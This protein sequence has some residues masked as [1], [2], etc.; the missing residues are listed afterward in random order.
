MNVNGTTWMSDDALVSG[1]E[2]WCPGYNATVGEVAIY[3]VA[4]N[5]WKST[6]TSGQYNAV[7]M[8]M[9]PTCKDFPVQ[10]Y[11]FGQGRVFRGSGRTDYM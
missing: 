4:G 5:C 10:D 1:Y 2:K 9:P 6:N 11:Q 7:C 8:K 3:E